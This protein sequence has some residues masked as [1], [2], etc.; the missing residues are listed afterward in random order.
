MNVRWASSGLLVDLVVG[1][2]YFFFLHPKDVS[3]DFVLV[4]AL[5]SSMLIRQ[6][7]W[8]FLSLCC[9]FVCFK[10]GVAVSMAYRTLL[11]VFSLG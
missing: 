8:V 10:G 2:T 9:F 6:C 11:V 1:S 4:G 7:F 5:V 3:L